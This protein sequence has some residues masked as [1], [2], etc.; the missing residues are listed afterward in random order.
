MV[1]ISE[2][3]YNSLPE[4]P[5][6]YD[7][8]TKIVLKKCIEARSAL[9]EL[10]MAGRL[11][12]NQEVLINV[13][14]LLEAKASSAIENIVTTTDKLFK[15]ADSNSKLL[16]AP[17]KE[18][19]RYRTALKTG[20]DL[21]A[22]KPLSTT[23]AVEVCS[24]IKGVEME[25][26]K[27][28]GT[29]LANDLTG[30]IIYTPPTGE[31]K[32]RD[33]LKNWENFLHLA[34]DL[35]PLI[36]MAVA[37]YQFEA[38][39]PFTDGNGRTGRILNILFLIHENLLTTPILYLS[40]YIMAN[41][42]DYYRLLLGVTKNHQWEAWILYILSAI[43]D[44]CRWTIDKIESIRQL[45]EEVS[46]LVKK[47]APTIYTRE[48]IDLIFTQ[49]YCRI[50]NIVKHGIAKRQ[51]ASVYLKKLCDLG[52]LIEVKEGRDK[53]FINT[54]MIDLLIK[55][56]QIKP[57]GRL[58]RLI[59]FLAQANLY[60]WRNKDC[61]QK[62]PEKYYDLLEFAQELNGLRNHVRNLLM[63][64]FREAEPCNRRATFLDYDH[65]RWYSIIINGMKKCGES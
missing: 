31:K 21:L 60:V 9:A 8:E 42:A 32:I 56:R 49:P 38:I 40:R 19:L 64:E 59:I 1:F 65:R 55:E 16:D 44:C 10:K 14:P 62:E 43:I 27:S 57:T 47:D 48:L 63:E 33:L 39:H 3:P 18:T 7:I 54:R 23:T 11:I 53:I 51:A 61:M 52:I 30:K 37:H 50:G 4:L 12:P 26:R 36:R 20:F 28:L 46:L 17:T 35:D 2:E 15:Y 5:P 13:I 22:T 24:V 6:K 29:K 58:V 41:K 34:T 25:I 45:S